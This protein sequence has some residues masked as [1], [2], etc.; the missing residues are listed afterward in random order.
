MWK[1]IHILLLGEPK[2]GK[3]S[4]ILALVSEEFPEDVPDRIEEITIP[5]DVTPEKVPTYIADYCEAEQHDYQLYEEISKA[6]VVCLVYD[7]TDLSTLSQIRFKWLPM[8]RFVE[9][10]TTVQLILREKGQRYCKC[11]S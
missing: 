11:F 4:L 10:I 3:T 5:A 9:S 8:I 7:L 6:N 2:V 1:D